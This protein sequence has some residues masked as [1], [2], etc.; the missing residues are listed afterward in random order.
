MEWISVKDR[1]PEIEGVEGSCLITDGKE[2]ATGYYEKEEDWAEEEIIRWFDDSGF[3]S[4]DYPG[5][6][7]VTHWT[8]LPPLP[9]CP[10]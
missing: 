9:D 10:N 5:L 3:I 2:I 4:C 7:Q 8:P 1:L 6:P